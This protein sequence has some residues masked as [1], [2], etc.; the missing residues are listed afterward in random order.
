MSSSTPS[1]PALP[2]STSTNSFF[3]QDEALWASFVH[4]VHMSSLSPITRRIVEEYSDHI[5]TQAKFL[6]QM[7]ANS[8]FNNASVHH[9]ISP[10]DSNSAERQNVFKYS[11]GCDECF[12]ADVV[13]LVAQ[14]LN[15]RNDSGQQYVLGWEVILAQ[16]QQCLVTLSG[17]YFTSVS[18]SSAAQSSS[19]LCRFLNS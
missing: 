4:D 9:Y 13:R 1:P 15:D 18:I 5:P 3:S 6:A 2:S 11:D 14:I 12:D 8:A 17:T 19:P 10:F 7:S 16:L